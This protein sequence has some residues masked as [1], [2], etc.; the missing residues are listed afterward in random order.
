[1]ALKLEHPYDQPGLPWLKGNLHTHTTLSD[2]PL[3][4]QETIAAYA[5][6]G[7]DFLMLSDHD[8]FTDPAELDARGMVLIPGNE[9]T[10]YGP[11]LLHVNAHRNI[12]PDEDRQAIIDAI[13][14]DGG[15]AVICHPNWCA[16]FNHCDQK[17]IEGWRGYT[18]IEIFNGVTF[19]ADGSPLA[20]DRWDRILSQGQEVGGGPP[21]R[22][23]WGFAHDDCHI[24]SQY[25]Y[26]WN[27][28]QSEARN[29]GSLVRAMR[30]GRFYASTGVTLDRI[31]VQDKTIHITSKDAQAYH[32]VTQDGRCPTQIE[33]PNLSFTVP[34]GFVYSYLRVEAFGHGPAMAWTQPFFVKR[35]D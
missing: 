16:D 8:H 7:H 18:G 35:E 5:E 4:P 13:N 15:F 26:A 31:E 11:H 10:A 19:L 32:V 25:G 6:L 17:H 2:G 20:T 24:P 28:V 30:Q 33:G 12:G 29:A 1:M 23:V 27:C 34:E 21:V 3:P 9:I 22:R 14:D